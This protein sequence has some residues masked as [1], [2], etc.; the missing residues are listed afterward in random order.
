MPASLIGLYK[1]NLHCSDC[2]KVLSKHCGYF[3]LAI[4]QYVLRIES[5]SVVISNN[6]IP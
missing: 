1:A 5:K 3:D 2:K 6:F 4:K